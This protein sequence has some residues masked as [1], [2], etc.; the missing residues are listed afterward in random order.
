MK[1]ALVC[2]TN[3]MYIAGKVNAFAGN[4]RDRA[5]LTSKLCYFI[6]ECKKKVIAVSVILHRS[7]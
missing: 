7:P 6:S 3:I 1:N 5:E 2:S 4:D